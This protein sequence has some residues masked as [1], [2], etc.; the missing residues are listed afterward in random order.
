M[1]SF[2]TFRRLK[3]WLRLNMGKELNVHKN[4]PINV[5]NIISKFGKIKQRILNFVI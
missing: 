4:V 2:S 1:R 3:T 5:N